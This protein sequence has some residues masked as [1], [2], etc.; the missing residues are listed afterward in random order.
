MTAKIS[1]LNDI[2][3]LWILLL[4]PNLEKSL[5][6]KDS[7]L[8][9]HLFQEGGFHGVDSFYSTNGKTNKNRLTFCVSFLNKEL[10]VFSNSPKK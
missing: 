4:I 6:S 9:S 3:H 5:S 1:W 7:R 2:M 10:N 8:H